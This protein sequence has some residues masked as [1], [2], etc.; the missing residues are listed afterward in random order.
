MALN[1]MS[2]CGRRAVTNKTDRQLNRST[3]PSGTRPQAGGS[4][5]RQRLQ[6]EKGGRECHL[7]GN[8]PEHEET[9]TISK[10]YLEQLMRESFMQDK[11][12]RPSQ[13]SLER[14]GQQS[15]KDAA[16]TRKHLDLNPSDIPG[17]G[18]YQ[19]REPSFHSIPCQ[20]SHDSTASELTNHQ[21]WLTHLAA[22]VE[23]NQRL[24][25]E[26]KL[27]REYV[28]GSDCNQTAA[29]E[30]ASKGGTYHR[31]TSNR[32]THPSMKSNIANI[33]FGG[34]GRE[35]MS[36]VG[37]EVSRRQW[38]EELSELQSDVIFSVFLYV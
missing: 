24:W 28:S 37:R 38:L 4:L 8:S 36:G 10:N 21:Q 6:A 9:V 11:L 32:P 15:G 22:Q 27:R 12:R 34:G 5:V 2:V 17:L 16:V 18:G 20:E 1:K 29:V 13:S 31:G 7:Q 35:T 26:E 14:Q 3:K 33:V 19:Q 23:E 25:E 30:I